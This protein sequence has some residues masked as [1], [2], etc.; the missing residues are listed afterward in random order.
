MSVSSPAGKT[1]F[2]PFL[3][4][5]VVCRA[6]LVSFS[7]Q[8]PAQLTCFD[9]RPDQRHWRWLVGF[10]LRDD[11]ATLDVVLSH[12][13]ANQLLS[14]GEPVQY[15]PRRANGQEE[16]SRAVAAMRALTGRMLECE[17]LIHEAEGERNYC[18]MKIRVC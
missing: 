11:S 18:A 10:K 6:K 3:G 5:T 16:C 12:N 7:P 8:V 15:D 9:P 2:L 13:V 17:L 4:E 14:G 1:C